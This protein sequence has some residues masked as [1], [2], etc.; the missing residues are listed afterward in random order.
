MK[1]LMLAP[2]SNHN[3][4]HREAFG[5]RWQSAAM[6]LLS[7]DAPGSQK[8]RGAALPAAVQN[9]GWRRRWLVREHLQVFDLSWGH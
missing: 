2:Q 9:R 3:L 8:R 1:P 4:S 5:L 6:T 7:E